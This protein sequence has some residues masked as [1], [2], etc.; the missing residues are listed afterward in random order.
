MAQARE[1]TS[2]QGGLDYRRKSFSQSVLGDETLVNTL[3]RRF[4]M[5]MN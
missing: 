2:A 3:K 4:P 5:G 1:L